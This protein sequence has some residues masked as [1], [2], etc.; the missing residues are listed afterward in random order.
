MADD[1]AAKGGGARLAGAVGGAREEQRLAQDGRLRPLGGREVGVARRKGEAVGFAHGVEEVEFD[2]E[3]QVAD[4]AAEHGAL[5][6]VFQAK[7][8]VSGAGNPEKLKHHG[9]DAAEM[10]GPR[11][12]RRGARSRLL[13]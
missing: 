2:A 10:S 7:D 4:H 13:R 11:P 9:A 1:G 12:G 6:E 3:I 8:G 5:L